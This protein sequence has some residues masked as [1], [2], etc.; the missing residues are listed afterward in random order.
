MEEMIELI[1]C[2]IMIIEGNSME[3]CACGFS[4]AH[5]MGFYIYI[6]FFSLFL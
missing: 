3:T 5:K 6:T 1:K 2:V 4:C